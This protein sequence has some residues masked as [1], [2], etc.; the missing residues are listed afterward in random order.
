MLEDATL[1]YQDTSK[2]ATNAFLLAMIAFA[3]RIGALPLLEAVHV[4]MKEVVHSVQEKIVTLLLSY[5][6]GC[7]SSHAIETHL[8]PEVLA[9]E[10]L[11]IDA[12]ADHSSFSRFYQRIDPAAIEALRTVVQ[13]L[14]EAH[15][16]ARHLAGNILVDF[17]AT[18]LIVTGEQ[19]ELADAGYFAKHRGVEGYQLSLACA[20]NA[21]KEVLAQILDPGHVNT[22][23][24]CWD[25]LYAV[26]E[27]LGFL[28]GR[29]FLRADR[30]YGIG[31]FIAHLLDME[32]GFLIKGRDPRTAHRWVADLGATSVWVPVDALVSVADIGPQVLPDCPQPVR[33]ILIRMWDATRQTYT[34]SYLVTT[35]PWAQ[36]SEGDVFHFY[37]ERV[38]LEKLIE[39][40][41]NAWHLTHRPT[42]AFWGLQ[43]YVE[44]RFLAYNLVLWYR[45]HVLGEAAC[46]QAMS[47]FVLVECVAPEAVVAERTAE[48]GWVIYL[49]HAPA[50]V[51]QVVAC[52]QAW[53]RRYAHVPLVLLGGLRR[54]HYDAQ[55]LVDA[56]WRAGRRLGG[57]GPPTLCKT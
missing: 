34:Y 28:D 29:V 52:T 2:H 12:F 43:F 48:A 3:Q 57:L 22:G 6:L 20:S 15:G 18:G 50:P 40:S 26:G 55:A 35:L 36:C 51:Q 32:V 16:L 56:V 11:G 31:A 44:L 9:A 10:V 5:T 14:H 1:D 49:A 27:R 25:L 53:L 39:Q 38:T 21:G 42:H 4:P 41:K 47:I 17:D 46:L 37:N 13:R 24:R 33:T 54:L 45:H 23:A 30:A 19:F 7:R 8:R